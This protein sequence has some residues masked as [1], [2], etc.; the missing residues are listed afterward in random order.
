S[1]PPF[2]EDSDSREAGEVEVFNLQRFIDIVRPAPETN[3]LAIQ[4]H[5]TSLDSSDLTLRP[6]LLDREIL[7]GSMENGDPNGEWVFRFDPE[8]HDPTSKVI[9]A[10]TPYEIRLPAGRTGADGALEAIEVIDAMVRHPSTAEFISIKLIQRFV[11]D[12]ISL[13]SFKDGS[14]PVELRE[15]LADMIAAWNSTE[16]PGHIGT[17]LRTLFDPAEQESAFWS[18]LARGS[19]V[20]T[21]IEFVNSTARIL[22]AD[23]DGSALPDVNEALGQTFFTRDDPD[24][25]SEIGSDWIDTGTVLNRVNFNV[26]FADNRS[27]SLRWDPLSYLDARGLDTPEEIIGFIDRVYFLETLTESD[28]ELLLEFLTTDA[29]GNP[30]PLDRSRTV[31]FRNRVQELIGLVLSLPQWHFQ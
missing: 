4:A 27:A 16:P 1:P 30:L 19:K 26:A 31:E 23:I 7:A 8:R 29:S 15:L 22:E 28:R 20:K 3:V 17:V 6:R 18:D 9:W 13:A 10:G 25:W 12:E 14:A 24:G 11:S 2:D 5:N 21:P